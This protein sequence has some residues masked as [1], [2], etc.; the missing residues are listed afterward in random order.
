MNIGMDLVKIIMAKMLQVGIKQRIHYNSITIIK[1][2]RNANGISEN[3]Y[4]KE[5]KIVRTS[6][7]KNYKTNPQPHYHKPHHQ[8]THHKQPQ[9][10]T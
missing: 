10:D 6:K 2:V 7:I 1:Y 5:V 3:P 4:S 9:K 8:P